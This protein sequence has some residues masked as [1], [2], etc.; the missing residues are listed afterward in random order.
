[1]T[2]YQASVLY[3]TWWEGPGIQKCGPCLS[4]SPSSW[5]KP[6]SFYPQRFFLPFH[7]WPSPQILPLDKWRHSFGTC[8]NV[9]LWDCHLAFCGSRITSCL[10]HSLQNTLFFDPKPWETPSQQAPLWVST[11]EYWLNS[12]Q[13]LPWPL[14]TGVKLTLEKDEG[15]DVSIWWMSSRRSELE[16]TLAVISSKPRPFSS[17]KIE[18]QR[19]D[20]LSRCHP[21]RG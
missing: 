11:E 18:A 19:G 7:S 12:T 4:Y 15:R 21:A 5:G 14:V 10:V 8:L 2:S 17:G 13:M 3:K 16:S 1:M 20:F 9:L 6:N